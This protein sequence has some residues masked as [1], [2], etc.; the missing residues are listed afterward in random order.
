MHA[1]H[2]RPTSIFAQ[3]LKIH[4]LKSPYVKARMSQVFSL[5]ASMF[6]VMLSGVGVSVVNTRFLGP[7]QFGDLKFLQSFFGFF[8]SVSTLGVFFAG[9]R[10]VAITNSTLRRRELYGGLILI[11][12][13][14]SIVLGFTLFIFSY[15]EER[16]FQNG[17]GVLIRIFAPLTIVF[18][19][20]ICLEKVLQGE[21]RIHE[22]SIFKIEPSLFYLF[23]AVFYNHLSG[24]DLKS[25]FFLYFLCHGVA[26]VVHIINF[27]AR[28]GH[29]K[30]SLKI[31][32]SETKSFGFPVYTG[33]L[34]NVSSIYVASILIGYFLDTKQVG[35]FALASTITMPLTLIPGAVGIV[36]YKDFSKLNSIPQKSTVFVMLLS[37]VCLLLFLVFIEPLIRLL[38]S[39]TFLISASLAKI[40]SA[41][42]IMHGI[43]DYFNKFI[44]ARGFGVYLRN[45]AIVVGTANILGFFILVY[46]F[47]TW[48]AAV[49]RLISGGLYLTL[50]LHSYNKAVSAFDEHQPET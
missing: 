4:M 18:P 25:A 2:E 11:S 5:Y 35:Y 9:G 7:E 22:L 27:R 50:M 32:V 13:F 39:N 6:V 48:G 16:L 29:L 1:V 17:L 23:C 49:T 42:C 21:N 19:F 28:F 43:G 20:Q 14:I 12:L 10:L 30:E 34:F 47:G 45:S 33:M 46:A 38:Y 44:G 41:G 31:I 36:L 8:V 15:I 3:R 26:V 37:I 40:M 24:L